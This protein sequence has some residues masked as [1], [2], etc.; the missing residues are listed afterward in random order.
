M[1]T[2]RPRHRIRP[3]ISQSRSKFWNLFISSGLPNLIKLCIKLTFYFIV[4]PFLCL[5]IIAA[6]TN[7]PSITILL[8][9]TYHLFI[10][11]GYLSYSFTRSNLFPALSSVTVDTPMTAF[12]HRVYTEIKYNQEMKEFELEQRFS[13]ISTKKAE[14]PIIEPGELLIHFN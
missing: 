14:Y 6:L 8:K 1:N 5:S 4:V 12:Q 11:F 9:S 10:Y 7:N 13:T 2:S 3:Q